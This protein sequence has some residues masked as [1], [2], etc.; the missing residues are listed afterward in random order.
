M[1]GHH[2]IR[3][4]WTALY[5]G[6]LLP[7]FCPRF[8]SPQAMSDLQVKAAYLYS[9]AKFVKWPVGTFPDAS[10][11]I[12][13]CILNDAPFQAQLNLLVKDK[14]IDG[15]PILVIPIHAGEQSRSCHELFIGASE[16]QNT[17]EIIESLHGTSVLTVGETNGF[18]EE[19]G[20]INFVL[21]D[22]HVHFQVN[23]KMANE[24]GLRMSSQLLSLA[25][26]VV[27]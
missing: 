5:I 6:L 14:N 23:Q 18:V 17:S 13:L 7:L 8:A 3:A 2:S 22:E 15:H 12:R 16:S 19:G 4:I 24:A 10:D 26:L 9:F 11:P 20:I 21:E 25:K 1:K 27:K